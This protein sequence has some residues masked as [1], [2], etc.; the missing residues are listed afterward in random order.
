MTATASSADARRAVRNRQLTAALVVAAIGAGTLAGA[1]YFQLVV[2]LAPCPLCLEQRIPYYVGVPVALIGAF[3]AVLGK[4]GPA[5]VALALAGMLMALGAFLAA[6]HAGVEWGFWA[7]PETCSGAGPAIGGG[8]LLGQLQSAR[9]VRCDEA[10]WR[11]LGL[12]L[13]GYNA[14]IAGALVV[15]AMW[16]ATAKA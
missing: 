2:G 15:V 9:V 11:L 10:P 4:E 8:D 6:Y 7:G 16:G 12:S 13:A 3:C 1:W 5:R 14:F